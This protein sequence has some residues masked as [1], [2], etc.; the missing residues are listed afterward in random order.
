MRVVYT[1]F[2][3]RYSS[4][5]RALFEGVRR[6]RPDWENL[7][8]AAPARLGDFPAGVPTVPFGGEECVAALE[9]ADLVISDDHIALDWE[10]RPGTVYLQTWHGTPLKR[11]HRDVLWAPPGRLD[12]LS[13]D[14]A[15]WDHLLSPNRVSTP[16]LRRAFEFTGPIHETGYPRNDVLNAPAA[17]K[18]RS[19]VRAALGIADSTTAVLYTPTWRDDQVFGGDGPDF[20]LA[21]D[22]ARFAAALGPDHALL[23]RTHSLVT[24][25]LAPADG[26]PLVDVSDYPDVAELYLAA[27]VMVTDYSSTMFDF[28]VTGKPILF[29]AYDL[30]DYRDRLRGFYFDLTEDPPGPVLGTEEQVLAALADLDPVVAAYRPAYERFRATF[31]HAEDGHATDRVL[32]LLG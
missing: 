16:R 21:I 10:K 2:S 11:I 9:G 22:P 17:S 26:G 14:V 24:H 13:E 28:A 31:G 5:P 29:Y 3:G 12:R 8:L 23:L 6:S 25:R 15:R 27:D 30:D 18:V 20:S 1:S 32:A 19:E 7:W 4:N